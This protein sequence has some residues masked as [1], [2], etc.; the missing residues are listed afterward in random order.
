M[1]QDLEDTAADGPNDDAPEKMDL[2]VSIESP[3]A[4]QRHVKVGIARD[5][6]DRY[7]DNAFSEMMGSADVPGFRIGRAPRKLVESRFRKDVTEQ[8]KGSLLMDAM[9]QVNEDH[10]ITAISEPDVDLD[11]VTVPDD[12]PMTFE[13]DIE[14][15]PE[16][17]MPN[18]KGLKI[19]R[20]TSD[21]TAED[22]DKQLKSVLARHGR[23]VPSDDAAAAED[24][25]VVDITTTHDGDTLSEASEQP[26]RV[27]PTLSFFDGNLEGFDKLMVGAKPGDKKSGQVQLSDDVANEDLKGKSVDVE[28]AV[29]E[30][31]KL[32]LP[33]L[34]EAFLQQMGGFETEA[35]L[36]DAIKD[37]LQRQLEYR[38]QQGTRQQ[39]SS[40]LTEAAEWELP[41]A[42]LQRQSDRELQRSVMELQRSGFGDADIRA[43]ENELRQNSAA[44]TA[45]SLREH[46]ILERIAED[47]DIDAD[48]PDYD[49]E[50]QLIAAQSGESPRRVRAQME[51]RG[52]MDSLRNQI[53]ER[54]VIE[55][56][57]SEAKFKDVPFEEE[58]GDVETIALAAGGSQA[59]IPEASNP[60]EAEALAE[61]KDHK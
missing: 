17:D 47:Q 24:F 4:C 46:F 43:H 58:G 54:K 12:G 39:I 45:R 29:T 31:K 49:M 22:I 13:F 9:A 60:E 42:M 35:D 38:Q 2:E 27:M 16:F 26:L 40:L 48:G 5:V 20:P 6:V 21:F 28:F 37:N 34:N 10:D 1:A 56:V 57:Q 14:V 51:K 18:W 61:P 52:M 50:L 59:D 11:G 44:A 41:P 36:R 8:I 3:S 23:L 55:L 32:E 33:E 25:V 7:L 53:V 19:E 30:I 15:R